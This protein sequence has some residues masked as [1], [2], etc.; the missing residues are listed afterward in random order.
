MYLE[1]LL[2]HTMDPETVLLI[3]GDLYLFKACAAAEIEVD[4]GEDIWSLMTNLRDAKDIFNRTIDKIIDATDCDNLIVAFSD[5]KNFRSDVDPTYKWGRKKTRK[6]VGYKGMIEWVKETRKTAQIPMLEAD[7]VLGI[8]G[9]APGFNVIM[10]SDDKD[11][12]SVPGQLYRPMT[13]EY[14]TIS[15]KQADMW[16]YK[17]ALMGDATDG[18]SGCPGIGEKTAEKILASDCSWDAVVKTYASKNLNQGHALTQ[19]RLARILRYDDWD[20]EKQLIKLWEPG[21]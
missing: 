15:K 14:S 1:R 20:H 18:Y 9:S 2:G 16:F 8:C 12:K 7:D 13:G 11:L 3:D 19:A 5:S 10:V 6:P 21:R 4:W 17:Q